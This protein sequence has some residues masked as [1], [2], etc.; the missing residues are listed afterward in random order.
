MYYNV[1]STVYAAYMLVIV[2]MSVTK[3]LLKL[4]KSRNSSVRYEFDKSEVRTRAGLP[5][6]ESAK[7]IARMPELKSGAL[8]RSAILPVYG[9][10]E[11]NNMTPLHAR[12]LRLKGLGVTCDFAHPNRLSPSCHALLLTPPR[13]SKRP[14]VRHSRWT[15]IRHINI[16]DRALGATARQPHY[17]PPRHYEA[18]D[19]RPSWSSSALSRRSV[20]PQP[21]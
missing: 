3:A 13:S 17:L 6:R 10:A 8:D 12:Q 5:H 1:Y 15:R 7:S 11:S 16:P 18:P 9:M 14:R 19:I 20:K 4:T 21:W 2:G